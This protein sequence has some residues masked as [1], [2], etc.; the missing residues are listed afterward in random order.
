MSLVDVAQA[1]ALG[2]GAKLPAG[3]DPGLEARVYFVPGTVTFGSGTEVAVG[4]RWTRRRDTWPCFATRSCT[5]LGA[6]SI[7]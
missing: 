7:R 6:G 3:L 4:C 5:T 2:P 1:A